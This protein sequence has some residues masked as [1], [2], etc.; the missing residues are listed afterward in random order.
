MPISD[1]P[2]YQTSLFLFRRDLRL[3]DNT[4]LLEAARLSRNLA[5]GFI[6]DPR[7]VHKNPFR[8]DAAVQF[9][10]ESL[11]EIDGSLREKGSQLFCFEGISDEIL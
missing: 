1:H 2:T 5:I 4:A 9:M 6:F 3:V 10:M 8:A 7:Q 11:E